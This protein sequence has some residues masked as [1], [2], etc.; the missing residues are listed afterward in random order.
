MPEASLLP[1]SRVAKI[2]NAELTGVKPSSAT[3]WISGAVIGASARE[4]ARRRRPQGS[5]PGGGGGSADGGEGGG[6]GLD[7]IAQ[8]SEGAPGGGLGEGGGD[9]VRRKDRNEDA[10]TWAAGCNP[11]PQRCAG[12]GRQVGDDGGGRVLEAAD[13]HAD[14]NAGAV[15]PVLAG[16]RRGC[17]VRLAR[18]AAGPV[19]GVPPVR[20]ES[21]RWEGGARP[22]GGEAGTGRPRPERGGSSK[23]R[24]G[25]DRQGGR[26]IRRF[27][28]SPAGRS[29]AH[30]DRE[31]NRRG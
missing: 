20:G 25:I 16:Q 6:V 19:G 9:G 5:S 10:D 28:A 29:E 31:T 18:C 17:R 12:V 30:R 11:G 13:V 2:G 23:G 26:G 8:G 1:F 7:A 15:G 27:L 21:R 3:K 24:K 22:R 14:A 4:S